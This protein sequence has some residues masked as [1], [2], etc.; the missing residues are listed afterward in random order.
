MPELFDTMHLSDVLKK[1]VG[2]ENRFVAHCIDESPKKPFSEAL[3]P[4]EE[5]VLLIGPEGD[6]RFDEVSLCVS[7][8]YKPVSMGSQR[9]RTETAAIAACAYFNMVNDGKS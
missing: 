1:F 4:C 3:V 8:G 5:T 2:V 6:F 9:L 7:Y